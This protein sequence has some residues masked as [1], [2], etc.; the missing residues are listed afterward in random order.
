MTSWVVQKKQNLY[1][2]WRTA[3]LIAKCWK[4]YNLPINGAIWMKLGWSHPTMSPTCPPWCNCH[5]NTRCLEMAYCTCSSYGRLE[6]ECLNQFWWNLVY[7]SKL[8]PKWQSRDQ[9]LNFLKFEMAARRD[10]WIYWKCHNSPT[11]ELI[12]TKLGWSHSITFPTCPPWC[13]CHGNDR[14]LA[15]AHWTFSSYG[16]L[17]AELVNQFWWNFV[18][19][20]MLRP[21]WQSRD[22]KLKF[23]KFKMAD[24]RHVGKYWKCYNSTTNG[25]IWTK[26]GWSHPIVF[27]VPD[28]SA[29][30]R[31][32]WERPLSSMTI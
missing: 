27:R 19:N 4:C 9:I 26:L 22:Q 12:G 14:C 21:Q 25:T 17:R 6:A 30:M 13:G 1:S 5:G 11:N 23:S 24:G 3:A 28:M 2:R 18:H 7:N 16:R 15:T 10:V 32:P 29:M 31:L 8:G 20:S